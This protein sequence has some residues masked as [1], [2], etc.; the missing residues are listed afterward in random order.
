MN[1]ESRSPTHG[2]TGAFGIVMHGYKS[3]ERPNLRF[4]RNG[5]KAVSSKKS[6]FGGLQIPPERVS[7]VLAYLLTFRHF[8]DNEA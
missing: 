5:R 3:S 7:A 2:A 1:R 8:L 6:G 4:S